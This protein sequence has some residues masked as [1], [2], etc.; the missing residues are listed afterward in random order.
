MEALR[1]SPDS[2]EVHCNL[3]M[4]LFHAGRVTEAVEHFE[5]ALR[6]E[7][8]YVD[9]HFDLGLALEK[10]GRTPEAIEQYQQTLKLRPDSAAARSALIRLG[11][12]K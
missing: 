7:P 2:P 6:I 11:A 1:L 10:L 5:Q 8:D 4:A 12:G 3:G 9:A